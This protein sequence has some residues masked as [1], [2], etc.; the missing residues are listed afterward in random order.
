MWG[1]TC[2]HAGI[3]P[4]TAVVKIPYALIDMGVVVGMISLLIAI[5]LKYIPEKPGTGA[6]E[7]VLGE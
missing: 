3:T 4:L 1:S 7:E 2:I 5:I 6:E